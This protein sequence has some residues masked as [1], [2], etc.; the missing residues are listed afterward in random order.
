MNT[1]T[2]PARETAVL[3]VGGLHYASEKARVERAVGARPGVLAVEGNPVAQTVTVTFDPAR[4]SV[5]ELREWVEKCGYHCAGQSVPGHIC[6]PMGDPPVRTG[7]PRMITSTTRAL[8]QA[9]V[10][11]A[12]GAGTTSRS[13]PRTGAHAIGP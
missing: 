10:G 2:A 7:L 8:A 12:I 5:R 9:D 11:I 3:H 13:R 1:T 6:D 4:T